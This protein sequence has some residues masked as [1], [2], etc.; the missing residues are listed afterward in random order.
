[1]LINVR[2]SELSSET[3]NSLP[4]SAFVL[5]LGLSFDRPGFNLGLISLNDIK[6]ETYNNNLTNVE[7]TTTNYLDI[8]YVTSKI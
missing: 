7:G 8:S 6:D 3:G 1:M 5:T 2:I 4:L